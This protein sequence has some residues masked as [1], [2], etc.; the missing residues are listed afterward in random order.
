MPNS[1]IIATAIAVVGQVFARHGADELREI[2][3]GDVLYEGDTIVTGQDGRIELAFNNNAQSISPKFE[4]QAGDVVTLNNELMYSLR[5]DATEK[6]LQAGSHAAPTTI[7]A[8]AVGDSED[9]EAPAAGQ[10]TLSNS[11]AY[12]TFVRLEKAEE[13]IANNLAANNDF[14]RD[15]SRTNAASAF[16]VADLSNADA[17]RNIPTS[18]AHAP[19]FFGSDHASLIE[20]QNA[21]NLIASGTLIVNDLDSG[22]SLIDT[23][24][25][26]IASVGALGSLS[27]NSLGEWVYLVP[28]NN[29]Q[30]LAEGE[31]RVEHF[32]VQSIDGGTHDIQ[33]SITGVNDAAV[34]SSA[35]VSLTESD[36]VLS[37]GGTLTISDIDNSQT[38]VAQAATTGA[39][40]VFALDTTG[41]WRYTASSA[42]NEFVAG[43]TYTDTFTVTAADGTT[44][45]VT[46]NITGTNDAPTVLA[47]TAI[48]TI[49]NATNSGS[50]NVNPTGN[51][52]NNDSDHESDAQTVSAFSVGGT[53]GTVGNA[54]AGSYGN[55]TLNSDGSYSYT[56][57][58]SNAGVQALR[59][60][61]TPLTET[62]TYTA[63]DALGASSDTTLTVTVRN[64]PTLTFG[65]GVKTLDLGS[66]SDHADAVALRSDGKL[67]VAGGS[68]GAI[69]LA[70]LNADGSFVSSFGTG[71]ITAIGGGM[72]GFSKVAFALAADD[73][74]VAVGW[75]YMDGTYQRVHRLTSTGALDTSF[76]SDGL[77]MTDAGYI[78]DAA[79]QNDG[80][81]LVA[82]GAA[83]NFGVQRFT[84]S[85]ALDTSFDGDGKRQVDTTGQNQGDRPSSML[86]NA[87][88]SMYLG[89]ASYGPSTTN[90]FAIIKL[91]SAGALDTSFGVNGIVRTNFNGVGTD[92]INQLIT[93]S[94]GKLLAAGR[95]GNYYYGDF[96]IARYTSSGALDTSFGV[97]GQVQVNM[98]GGVIDDGANAIAQQ[99]D[100]KLIVA[101]YSINAHGDKDFAIVR[102][103]ANGN[104]DTSFGTGGKVIIDFAGKDDEA[105]RI[106][107]QNLGTANDPD[108]KIVIVGYTTNAAG[109]NKDAVIVRL[110]LDGSLDTSFDPVTSAVFT[111]AAN[112]SGGAAVV[113]SANAS[114]SDQQMNA[115]GNYNGCTLTLNRQGGANS[116][117]V[118]SV[119]MGGT[120]ATLTEGGDLIVGGLTIGAVTTNHGGAL[121]LTFNNNATQALVNSA[122]QQIAYVNNADVPPSSVNIDWTFNDGA[123]DNS[124]IVNA[125]TTVN[126]TAANDAPVTPETSLNVNENGGTLTG[127]ILTNAH[128]AE[129]QTMSVSGVVFDGATYAAGATVTGVYGTLVVNS[130]GSY[131]YTVDSAHASANGLFSGQVATDD[132]SIRTTDGSAVGVSGLAINV[133]GVGETAGSIVTGG[134]GDDTLQASAGMDLIVGGSGKDTLTGG[135]GSDTFKWALN[136]HGS[137]GHPDVD[138]ITDFDNGSRQAGGDALDLRD[139]L[140]GESH[141]GHSV[142]NLSN[143]LH[144][145]H[146]GNDTLVHISTAGDDQENLTIALQGVDLIGSFS[147]DAQL[148]HDLLSRGKLVTD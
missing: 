141:Q 114:I 6:P 115:A 133:T 47:D 113:L 75:N 42:H 107:I 43:A 72:V 58:H 38:F 18:I 29:V 145:E 125:T 148:I 60:A 76:D 17:K 91:T 5:S 121:T 23:T 95:G 39:Y 127:N 20:D 67:I 131:T 144:F 119:K 84:T 96:A 14:P 4:I 26:P 64:A 97:G 99:A 24:V 78:G 101:G 69:G 31:T 87:D 139:L 71:G 111:E 106:L 86:V 122:I 137:V 50:I 63:R 51:V 126:I 112:G 89:G 16:N 93:Q 74:M 128:D 35:T 46:V 129:G 61:N 90:D 118:F 100:G 22:Q 142:G 110:N 12:A 32:T 40:G 120:L 124:G 82:G 10:A 130:N 52:L 7:A 36:A 41:V 49:V 102:L 104:V 21:P 116:D 70:E 13:S 83:D 103:T 88:G 48:A 33:I 77:I 9:W 65:D 25:A 59:Y 79:I 1:P 123:S 134:N 34:L 3:I 8:D 92:G 11:S 135:L 68:G 2:R 138:I 98:S 27:I 140:Q 80:K 132:F 55:L 73:S 54:L 30:Y 57:D 147:N 15:S 117:D 81:V 44:S 45:S 105:K 56:V 108:Y 66:T 62:F 28:N 37:T 136:D 109:N 146:S 85:G 143:Y 94:D 19:T 53:T